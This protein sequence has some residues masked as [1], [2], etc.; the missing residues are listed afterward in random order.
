MTE[1]IVTVALCVVAIGV[2][3]IAGIAFWA[4]TQSRGK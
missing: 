1:L 3:T 4:G 2:L